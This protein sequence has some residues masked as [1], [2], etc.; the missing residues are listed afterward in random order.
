M[1][2]ECKSDHD[3]QKECEG[4]AQEIFDEMLDEME[5]D[6]T[7]EHYHAHR[8]CMFADTDN[9][10]AFLEDVGMP[11]TVTYDSL[12]STIAYGEIRARIDEHLNT[13]IDQWE[14]SEELA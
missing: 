3:L 4:L 5:E 9:G 1:T 8:V 14:P 10:E 11:E 13:L 6:E 2:H 12:A 7:P